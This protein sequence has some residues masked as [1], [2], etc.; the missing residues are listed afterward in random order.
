[1]IFSKSKTYFILKLAAYSCIFI[2]E[3]DFLIFKVMEAT[4]DRYTSWLGWFMCE[5]GEE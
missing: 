5:S 3:K 2:T 4:V 1:M